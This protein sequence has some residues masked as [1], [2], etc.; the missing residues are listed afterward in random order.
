MLGQRVSGYEVKSILASGRR[1]LYLAVNP[2]TGHRAVVRSLAD[3]D[4]GASFVDFAREVGEVLELPRRPEVV[5]RRLDD[6]REVLV[7]LVDPHAPGTGQTR[8]PATTRLDR[9]TPPSRNRALVL[10]PVVLLVLGLVAFGAWRRLAPA[11]QPAAPVIAAAPAV[12]EPVA[13][14]PA[15]PEPAA[16]PVVEAAKP[17]EL[18]PPPSKQARPRSAVVV[19]KVPAAPCAVTDEWR[20]HRLADLQELDDRIVRSDTLWR[21]EQPHLDRLSTLIHR[22]R[23]ED[24]CRE[25]QAE[26]E[27]LVARIVGR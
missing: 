2:D 20:K 17:A 16:V 3:D 19:T 7:A 18:A 26:L 5:T 11:D 15:A 21:Q 8:F 27:K 14:P 1:T 9:A 4:T 6:G 24:D 23:D 25:V 12:V 22:A 13:A 10:L